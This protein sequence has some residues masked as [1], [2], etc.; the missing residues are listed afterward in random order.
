MAKGQTSSPQVKQM[1]DKLDVTSDGSDAKISI[2]MSQAKLN[3]LVQMVGG[4]MG[5]M[6]GAGGGMGG[7]P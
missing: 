1:F 5:G 6:M 2:A 4:M 3:S 7:T